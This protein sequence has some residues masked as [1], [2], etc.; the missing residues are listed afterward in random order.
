[1]AGALGLVPPALAQQVADAYRDF[2]RLQ[3]RLRLNGAEFARVERAA[4]AAHV[5]AT[6]ALWQ[7]VFG[8]SD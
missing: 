8:R 1:M 6:A 3:H 2:R 5:D 7:A 4:V